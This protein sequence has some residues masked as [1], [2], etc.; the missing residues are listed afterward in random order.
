MRY[1]VQIIIKKEKEVTLI[2]LCNRMQKYGKKHYRTLTLIIIFIFLIM[3]E[4]KIT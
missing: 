4:Q 3:T 1:K 2:L